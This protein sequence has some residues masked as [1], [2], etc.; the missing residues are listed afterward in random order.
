MQDIRTKMNENGRIIIPAILRKQLHLEAGDELILRIKDNE[1]RIFS[2]KQSLRKA[3]LLVKKHA[4]NK[5][6]T[7]ELKNLRKDDVKN[8]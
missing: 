2:L 7:Q 3:Q 1:L 6:L 5:K 8:E 4:K